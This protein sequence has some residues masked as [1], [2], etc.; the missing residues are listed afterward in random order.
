MIMLG[1][2]AMISILILQ[3]LIQ[4]TELMEGAEFVNSVVSMKPYW[5]LRTLSGITMDVGI[6]LVGINLLLGR[7]AAAG[8]G[9]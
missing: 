2:S 4:G 6:A 8:A 9:R 5:F 1:I 3:G 7:G